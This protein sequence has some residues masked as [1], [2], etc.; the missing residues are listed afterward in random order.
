MR[1]NVLVVL[2]LTYVTVTTALAAPKK[3]F[4]NEQ[5]AQE[6]V[7]QFFA[8]LMK[9]DDVKGMKETVSYP[10]SSVFVTQP[11]SGVPLQ[12][13]QTDKTEAEF[14][15]RFSLF[16]KSFEG[17]PKSELQKAKKQLGETTFTGFQTTLQGN[18]AYVTCS[19]QINGSVHGDSRLQKLMT[20]LQ[21]TKGGWKIIFTT[22][23]T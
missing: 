18:S 22:L 1:K 9:I 23:P 2:M 10:F 11:N 8:A 13:V 21:K 20:V 12:P 7:Q 16:Q 6:T 19:C 3:E 17:K 4:A 14:V 15:E 5:K